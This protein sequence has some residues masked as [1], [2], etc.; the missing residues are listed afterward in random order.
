[1]IA[2][3]QSV[4]SPRLRRKSTSADASMTSDELT[5]SL[6]TFFADDL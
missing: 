3:A 6:L 2:P 1:M 4:S 5:L